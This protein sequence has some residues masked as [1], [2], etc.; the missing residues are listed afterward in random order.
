[1]EDIGI[2]RFGT[3]KSSSGFFSCK[4]SSD[5]I[6]GDWISGVLSECIHSAMNSLLNRLQHGSYAGF[7]MSQPDHD[8]MVGS[9]V[10]NC[11]KYSLTNIKAHL[12]GQEHPE[13]YGGKIP[14]IEAY[15]N[16]TKYLIEIEDLESISRSDTI[17]QLKVFSK[18]RTSSKFKLIIVVPFSPEKPEKDV[19]ELLSSNGISYDNIWLY[20]AHS[21]ETIGYPS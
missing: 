12:E 17:E 1:M 20:F 19:K 18:G 3:V 16:G 5:R 2:P 11:V 15:K 13:E 9:A 4:L 10:K 14:D 7:E 6:E 21:G 8:T